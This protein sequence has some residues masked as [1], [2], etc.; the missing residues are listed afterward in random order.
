M[1]KL[2]RNIDPP[3]TGRNWHI[4][5]QVI[6]LQLFLVDHNEYVSLKARIFICFEEFSR[7]MQSFPSPYALLPVA[8]RELSPRSSPLGTTSSPGL[9]LGLF[10][11]FLF[12]PLGFISLENYWWSR[13]MSVVFLGKSFLYRGVCYEILLYNNS[14]QNLL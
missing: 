2:E 7:G 10:R 12:S 1:L 3:G 11:P 9:S 6:G 14:K 4:G 8:V 5:P 13:K